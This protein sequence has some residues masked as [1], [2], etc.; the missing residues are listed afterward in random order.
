MAPSQTAA[1]TDAAVTPAPVVAPGDGEHPDPK[2]LSRQGKN[3]RKDYNQDLRPGDGTGAY[4]RT[5]QLG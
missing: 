5:Y 1:T 4:D 2:G 3:W